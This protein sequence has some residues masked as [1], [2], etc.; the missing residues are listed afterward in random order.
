MMKRKMKKQKKWS[1]IG[2]AILA[3]IAI[4][5]GIYVKFAAPTHI[6]MVNYPEYMLA[7]QLDQE[8]NPMIR[9]TAQA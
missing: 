5:T 9:V 1:I 6:A 4:L 7:P 3:A 8:L 2:V